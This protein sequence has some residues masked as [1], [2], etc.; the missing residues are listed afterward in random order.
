[1]DFSRP[2][3]HDVSRSSFKSF[4]LLYTLALFAA[5]AGVAVVLFIAGRFLTRTIRAWF[6]RDDA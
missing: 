2:E 6:C 1:M 5:I 3:L 4:V